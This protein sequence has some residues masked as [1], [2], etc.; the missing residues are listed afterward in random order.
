MRQQMQKIAEPRG[1]HLA[2]IVKVGKGEATL[3][4]CVDDV[5]IALEYLHG[6]QLA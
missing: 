6:L 1:T 5:D 4:M 2:N 3:L